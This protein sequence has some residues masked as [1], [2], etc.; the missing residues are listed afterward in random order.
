MPAGLVIFS[1]GVVVGMDGAGE[2]GAE[3]D[4]ELCPAKGLDYVFGQRPC[5]SRSVLQAYA[6]K[7][8]IS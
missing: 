1:R 2:T 4:I 5:T 6:N 8:G 3:V 7:V